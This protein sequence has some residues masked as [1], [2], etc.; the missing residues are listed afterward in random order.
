LQKFTH[1]LLIPV[2]YKEGFDY[3][4]KNQFYSAGAMLLKSCC[5]IVL[6]LLAAGCQK[7]SNPKPNPAP[8]T[9]MAA[10]AFPVGVAV[11]S[12]L[13]QT[14]SNYLD[15]V[16]TQ[17]NSITTA[18]GM[19]FA[20]IEP[21][22]NQY[23]F[24]KGDYLIT[25]AIHNA[26][27]LNAHSLISNQ[28]LPAWV[29]QFSGDTLD[30]ENLFKMHILNV[31]WHYRGQINTWDVVSDAIRDDD[32]T[33]R[34]QDVNP[35]DGSI[36]C[37]HLGPDYIGRAF[38]YARLADP[39]ALLF[40]DDS[41]VNLIKINSIV[42]LVTKLKN[43]N[44]P[45]DGVGLQLHINIHTNQDSITVALQKLAATGLKIQIS[46]L[47]V[48]IN[49]NNDPNIVLTDSL[50]AE[51]AAKYQFV[52]QTYIGT[53]PKAQRYGITTW[54]V[55]DADSWIPVFFKRKDWP[56]PFDMTYKKKPAYYALLK[57]L[58]Y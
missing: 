8:Q 9:L 23:D 22:P 15:I 16:R 19:S 1:Y 36:W 4:R 57:G 51:Q 34:N 41:G 44:I 25:F 55:S 17:Y 43:K 56:L 13:M 21:G 14:N 54:D 26:K 11:N 48:S 20:E 12:A 37:R 7:K 35:G 33:L 40:Y 29:Y 28:L 31:A 49:P 38:E 6:L 24:Y 45:I 52:A 42:S 2:R 46:A 58:Q 3:S 50:Q 18:N 39:I 27:R 32:G 30:W 47:D 53:I 5:C 10:A